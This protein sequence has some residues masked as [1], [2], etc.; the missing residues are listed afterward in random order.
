MPVFAERFHQYAGGYLNHPVV[1]QTGLKG[2]YDFSIRWTGRQVL[3]QKKEGTSFFEAAEK[4]LGLK[5]EE[6]KAPF[7]GDGD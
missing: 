5:F 2:G 6:K 3:D 1:D 4:Q 7:T